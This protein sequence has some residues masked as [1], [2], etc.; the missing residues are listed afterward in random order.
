MYYNHKTVLFLDGKMVKAYESATDLY[1]QTLHYGYG[2]FEGIRAYKTES[3]TQVFKAEEHYE[4]LKKSC[5][6]VK[7]PF[8]YKVGM[9]LVEATY[10][11][12]EKKQFKRCLRPTAGILHAKYEFR[13]KPTNVSVMIAVLGL[14]RLFR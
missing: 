7:I 8:E 5:E 9:E 14:G 6:L 3:G 11:L 2:A 13:D 12:L 1:S 10:Q 4:R